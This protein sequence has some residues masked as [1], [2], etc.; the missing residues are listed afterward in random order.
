MGAYVTVIGPSDAQVEYRLTGHSGCGQD[1]RLGYYLDAPE[2]PLRWIGRGAEAL[3]LH[4]GTV[5]GEAQ[6]DAARAIMRGVH[7]L[8]GEQL[9]TPKTAAAPAALLPR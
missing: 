1:A 6:Y 7:P 3:G 2:R 8:T 9:V 4:A 5:L